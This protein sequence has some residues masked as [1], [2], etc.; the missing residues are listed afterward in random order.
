MAIETK[1][2]SRRQ[3]SFLSVTALELHLVILLAN[4]KIMKTK[5][6]GKGRRE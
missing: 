1:V 3:I 6:F 5:L 4:A 2:P